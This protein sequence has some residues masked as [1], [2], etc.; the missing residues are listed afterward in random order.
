MG[1]SK[2]GFNICRRCGGAEVADPRGQRKI[3]VSQP[4]HNNAPVCRHEFIEQEV[5]LGYEFLTDMFMLDISYD[6]SKLVGRRTA[7]ERLILR[8]AATTLLEAIKKAISQE[9]DIDYNEV[10]GGW[11]SRID[12]NELLHLELFFYDNLTSGAGYSSLISGYLES[13]FRRA[14]TILSSCD[15]SRTCKNCLDNY[16][17]QR[18]HD[19]FDRRLGLQLLD[20]AESGMLPE[21]Y[22]E[23]EQ[24]HLLIPLKRLICDEMNIMENDI[25]VRF[26]VLPAL[27]RKPENT[28]KIM[29]VNPYDLSD[30]LP[31]TFMDYRT[32]T[33]KG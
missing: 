23:S 9:L 4:F 5:F 14:R 33:S 22:D 15:C 6:S 32:L 8:T 31:N 13:I 18:S 25:P 20:Y 1:K 7:Q 2:H 29:F 10:N 24:K 28:N 27:Y 3:K 21:N 11:M 26:E 12:S 16:Y 19:F 30:W 17:N